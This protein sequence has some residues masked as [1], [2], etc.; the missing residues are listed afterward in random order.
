MPGSDGVRRD[1][2]VRYAI[3][4]S[5]AL[6]HQDG[7]RARKRRRPHVRPPDF[8]ID[9]PHVSDLVTWSCASFLA[10]RKTLAWSCARVASFSARFRRWERVLSDTGRLMCPGKQC[11]PSWCLARGLRSRFSQ[12]ISTRSLSSLLLELRISGGSDAR[13][14]G[15]V[16]RQYVALKKY[17]GEPRLDVSQTEFCLLFLHFSSAFSAAVQVREEQEEVAMR[18]VR[19]RRMVVMVMLMGMMEGNEAEEE[20][21]G[22]VVEE[23]MVVMMPPWMMANTVWSWSF[24]MTVRES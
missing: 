14:R 10:A 17:Y 16:E 8:S 20:I 11:W 22:H 24:M 1:V 3:S 12:P 5:G 6:T 19:R 2:V 13:L 9:G 4:R 23:S 18:A 15:Q 21:L 7:T